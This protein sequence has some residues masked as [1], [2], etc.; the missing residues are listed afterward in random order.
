MKTADRNQKSHVRAAASDALDEG[1]KWANEL[2]KEGMNIVNKTEEN[3]KG[4][5]DQALKNV[6]ENPLASVLIGALIAGG[7][8]FLLYRILKE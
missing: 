2:R 4:Y 7:I 1:K 8:G 3:L 5:S 6:Q